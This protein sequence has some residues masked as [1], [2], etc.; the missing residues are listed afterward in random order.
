MVR[1]RFLL[2]G[3]GGFEAKMSSVTLYFKGVQRHAPQTL[4]RIFY[5]FTHLKFLFN[6]VYGLTA[7]K[8]NFKHAKS[9]YFKAF[10]VLIFTPKSAPKKLIFKYTFDCCIEQNTVQNMSSERLLRNILN[11]IMNRDRI[12]KINTSLPIKKKLNFLANKRI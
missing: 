2:V 9:L 12:E 10:L 1:F 6:K 8:S 4:Q 11:F 7:I 5:S 3:R